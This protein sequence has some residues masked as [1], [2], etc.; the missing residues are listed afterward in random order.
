VILRSACRFISAG[1]FCFT[2]RRTKFLY[3]LLFSQ[4]LRRADRAIGVV[5]S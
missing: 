4:P 3:A 2:R 1:I 5:A